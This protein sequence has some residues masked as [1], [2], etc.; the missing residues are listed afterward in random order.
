ML[1]LQTIHTNTPTLALIDPRGRGARSVQYD[2]AQPRVDRTVHDPAGRAIEL[3]D[4]RLFVLGSGPSNL[5]NIYSLSGAILASRSVDAGLRVSVFGEAGQP[6]QGWDGRGSQRWMRYDE[7]LRLCELYEQ[8]AGGDSVCAE[9]LTY[10]ANDQLFAD[11][12]HC[13]RLIQH[14]DPAGVLLFNDYGLNG[15]VLEQERRLTSQKTDGYITH[16]RFNPQGELICVTDAR[17][18]E[19]HFHQTVGGALRAMD[20]RLYTRVNGCQWFVALLTT[21][22]ARSNRKSP[23]TA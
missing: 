12:N 6:V 22:T 9:R 16:S 17:G 13:G 23:A 3:W 4:A 15:A 20:L 14:D 8:A 2:T 11:H 1:H 19:Q 5:S 21:L 18:N 7:Q 10:A